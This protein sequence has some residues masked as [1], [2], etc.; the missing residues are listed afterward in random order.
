MTH[1]FNN[2]VSITRLVDGADQDGADQR[3][4]LGRSLAMNI[5]EIISKIYHHSAVHTIAIL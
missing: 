1:R 3:N 4:H 5:N 2:T